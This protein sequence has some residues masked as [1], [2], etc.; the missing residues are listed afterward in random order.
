MQIEHGRVTLINS[1]HSWH[2]DLR[3]SERISREPGVRS[4]RFSLGEIVISGENTNRV[5]IRSSKF[6]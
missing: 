3:F 6:F 4:R 5:S 1:S 2:R